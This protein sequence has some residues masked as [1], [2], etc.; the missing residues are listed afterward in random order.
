MEGD[1]H[2]RNA[3]GTTMSN[4]L[5]AMLHKLDVPLESFGDSTGAMSL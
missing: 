1:R 2:L 3:E 4:L 5:L